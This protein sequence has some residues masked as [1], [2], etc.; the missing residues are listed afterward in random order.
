M[1]ELLD[2]LAELPEAALW[3]NLS[4]FDL[5]PDATLFGG[6]SVTPSDLDA[7]ILLE[8]QLEEVNRFLRRA[9]STP[10]SPA[11]EKEDDDFL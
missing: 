9:E 10:G 5:N 6:V 2:Q 7:V 3:V 1:R 4:D 8:D 11:N